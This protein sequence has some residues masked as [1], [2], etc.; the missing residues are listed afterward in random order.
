MLKR[1]RKLRLKGKEKLTV[2]KQKSERRDKVRM[3]KAERRA[4]LDFEIEKEMLDR[5]QLGTYQ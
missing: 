5:L 1:M 3:E 2:V 4:Q